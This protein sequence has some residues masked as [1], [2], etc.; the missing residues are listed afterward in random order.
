MV[1]EYGQPFVARVEAGRL[2]VDE[3][4]AVA[5]AAVTLLREGIAS[6]GLVGS[7]VLHVNPQVLRPVRELALTAVGTAS[8]FH[9]IFTERALGLAGGLPRWRGDGGE[10]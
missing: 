10:G 3:I 4:A 2:L 5:E 6:L 1:R 7:I 9:E 8:S